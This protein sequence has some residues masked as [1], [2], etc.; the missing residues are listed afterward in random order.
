MIKKGSP[1]FWSGFGVA[2]VIGWL[3]FP[4]ILYRSLEQPVQFSHAIHTGE[5][6]G[7]TCDGC[8]TF[9]NDGRFAGIP[10]LVQ[11][12]GCH[13]DVVGETEAEEHFVKEYIKQRREVPWHVYARQPDNAHFSHADHVNVGGIVCERCHGSHGTSGSLR[14]FEENRISGYSRDIWGANISGVKSNAWE[15]MK[16]NDCVACHNE[17]NH[18]SACLDCHK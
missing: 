11:C 6:V 9:S 15:G 1:G 10:T 14:P 2:L 7:M 18:R 16:M 17:N 12:A 8:H 4:R 3:A 5:T 13:A